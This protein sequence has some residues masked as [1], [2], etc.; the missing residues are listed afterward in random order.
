MAKSETVSVVMIPFSAFGHLIPFF[1]L[2]IAL[3]KAGVHVF[4]ISTPR[5]I[6][7]LPQVP[8]KLSSLLKFVKIQLPEVDN[9]LLPKGAEATVDVPVEKILCLVN[10]YDLLQHPIKKFVADQSPDYIVIDFATDWAVDIAAECH[11]PLLYFSVYSSAA[12]VFFG[13]P[14]YMDGQDEQMRPSPE[15]L[16]RPSQWLDFPSLV[17]YRE[18][19][20]IAAYNTLFC[21]CFSRFAKVLNAC[22]AVAIR[23]CMEFE[24]NFLIAQQKMMGSKPVIPIGLLPPPEEKTEPV[25]ESWGKIFQWLD[26]QKSKTV[27]FICF[28]SECRL[29]RE[30]VHEIAYGIELSGLPFLWALRKPHWAPPGDDEDV[31]KV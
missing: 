14:E 13:P 6:Q 22:Q 1:Q 21:G 28:G 12:C 24:G 27:V 9:E 31:K 8:P 3:A 29:T 5:N 7:R 16:T 20:A 19:E 30:Q 26:E 25:D 10:A 2:S 11:I 23:S 18:F 17:A 4:F 15:S